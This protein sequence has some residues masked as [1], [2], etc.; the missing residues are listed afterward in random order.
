M[1]HRQLCVQY[2]K[3]PSDSCMTSEGGRQGI[4]ITIQG[5]RRTTTESW[6]DGC[7]GAGSHITSPRRDRQKCKTEM[8]ETK[9][10]MRQLWE[11]HKTMRSRGI[12]T[13]GKWRKWSRKE[14][15]MR[16]KREEEAS[17]TWRERDQ[18]E[19]YENNGAFEGFEAGRGR[20]FPR[21]IK[22]SKHTTF[23]R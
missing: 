21:P 2:H 20:Q 14:Y 9:L 23:N 12:K 16:V 7:G 18:D 22:F 6:G 11:Q 17:K 19:K 8:K 10:K 3:R 5:T 4:Q 13:E 15:A 1:N